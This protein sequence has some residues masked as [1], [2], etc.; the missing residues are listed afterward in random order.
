MQM[1]L[2]KGAS[3][4]GID[5]TTVASQLSAGFKGVT[6]TELQ[7]GRNSYEIDIRLAPDSKD[8]LSD[9]DNFKI[10]GVLWNV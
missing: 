9:L 4:L 3:V 2:K 6:A 1:K 8:S 5:A 10:V 7:V